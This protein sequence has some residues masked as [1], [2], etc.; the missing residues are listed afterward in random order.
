M[1]GSLTVDVAGKRPLIGGTLSAGDMDLTGWLTPLWPKAKDSSGWK[2]EK[3]PE[4]LALH[5]DLDIR[6]S[7]ER[8]NLGIVRVADTAVTIFA[9][10]GSLDIGVGSTHLFQ[11]KAKGK[12][13]VTPTSSGYNLQSRG[14]FEGIDLG[15]LTLAILDIKR[16][17]GIASGKFDLESSGASADDVMHMI[18]GHAEGK[19][20]SG[21][22]T[23]VNLANLLRRIETRPLSV[24]RDMRG[25]RTDF[26]AMT[27]SFT[28]SR[29]KATLDANE[30]TFPPNTMKLGGAIDIG[31]RSLDLTGEATGPTPQNGSEPATLAFTVTGDFDDPIVTPDINR[32]LKRNSGSTQTSE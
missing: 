30:T 32:I 29:G 28:L 27:A 2:L 22:L 12:L 1:N 25:G 24:I 3:L 14:S 17:E 20:A 18:S 4:S 19:I 11:G 5:Q 9:K 31:N 23:G 21:S 26:D 6:L 16:V 7:A 10:D 8:V 15:Q 13:T